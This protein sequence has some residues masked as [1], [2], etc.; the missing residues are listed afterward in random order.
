MYCYLTGNAHTVYKKINIY[1][2]TLIWILFFIFCTTKKPVGCS[3]VGGLVIIKLCLLV[4]LSQSWAWLLSSKINAEVLHMCVPENSDILNH[5]YF[6]S[7]GLHLENTIKMFTYDDQT[8]HGVS[9]TPV[10]RV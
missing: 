10:L 3:S 9:T 6:C 1:V 2:V 8:L 7:L 5:R 4:L